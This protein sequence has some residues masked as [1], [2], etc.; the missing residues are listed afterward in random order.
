MKPCTVAPHLSLRPV[1]ASTLPV[2]LQVAQLPRLSS[3]CLDSCSYTPA[4]LGALSRLSG[5]LTHLQLVGACVPATLS[6]LTNL[7]SLSLWD[8]RPPEEGDEAVLSGALP[9]LRQLSRL[10][11]D[12]RGGMFA[13]A[14]TG[15]AAE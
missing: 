13:S 6:T 5:S 3:L 1:I 9:H 10:V 12:L 15:I 4:S 11:S 7:Q 8:S 14:P 2:A